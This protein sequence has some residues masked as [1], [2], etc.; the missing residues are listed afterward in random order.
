MIYANSVS[1]ILRGSSLRGHR[2]SHLIPLLSGIFAFCFLCAS[3]S[4][5]NAKC[6]AADPVVS[7]KPPI[8][9]IVLDDLFDYRQYRNRFGVRILTPNLDR[10]A[11]RGTSF[12]NAFCSIAVC[13]ASRSSALSGLSPV[14]T[15]IH[16]PEPTQFFDT[17]TPQDTLMSRM[18]VA[19]YRVLGTGKVMHTSTRLSDRPM[20]EQI[21][22]EFFQA[23][24][25]LTLPAGRAASVQPVGVRSADDKHVAWAAD[26]LRN[27]DGV[28]EPLFLSV[29]I[30]RPHV[31]FIVPQKYFGLYNRASIRVPGLAEDDLSDVSTF[32]KLFRLLLGYYNYLVNAN[33]E[34]EFIH[35]YLASTSYADAKV[36]EILDAIDANPALANA[37]IML[38]S[39]NGYE[40][41]DKQTWNKFTLWESSAKVPLIVVD[42]SLPKGRSIDHSVSLLDI[43]PTVLEW[44]GQPIPEEFDGISLLQ[45]AANRFYPDRRSVLTT[46]LGTF[47]VRRRDM[48]LNLYADG[49]VELY[50][51]RQDSTQQTNLGARPQWRPQIESMKL[52]LAQEIR[53]QG[54]IMDLDATEL[55][56]TAS[57]DVMFLVGDQM[58]SG[59]RGNDTYFVAD[60]FANELP[61]GGKDI[62]FFANSDYMV[63]DNVETASTYPYLNSLSGIPV[64]NIVGSKQRNTILV[65]GAQGEVYARGGDDVV[66]SRGARDRIYGGNGRDEIHAGGNDDILSGGR[67]ED[68]LFGDAGDDDL[69]GGQGSDQLM[70]GLGNDRFR[71]PRD[72]TSRDVVTDFTYGDDKIWLPLQT[73]L[74]GLNALQ[75]TKY[76]FPIGNDVLI[77]DGANRSMLIQNATVG[78][79]RLS[80][81]HE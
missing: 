74:H 49:S 80:F 55:H 64:W 73:N 26:K 22:D 17:L 70:G 76:L 62:V 39:D 56:G 5:D 65:F 77:L 18:Q 24:G 36:G 54:G 43:A 58:A 45:T 40:L 75:I 20:M 35:G 63:P 60:G 1:R 57:D 33:L 8:V 47:S 42:P 81:E 38:W 13:N 28:G 23:S 44:A 6:R 25:R 71:F 41:G 10:L 61:S 67:G 66:I 37:R 9:M 2:L 69:D 12:G 72:L 79:I 78:Q 19:G 46:M 21:H 4:A 29:G 27:W 34:K 14:K 3:P 7:P 30:I 15:K 51:M 52:S 53:R 31:P 48:R 50:H 11:A 68:Q 32:Y 59:G 16:Q